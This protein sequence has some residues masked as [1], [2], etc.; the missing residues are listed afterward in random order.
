[1]LA[2]IFDVKRV[3]LK[4]L[5]CIIY[6]YVTRKLETCLQRVPRHR[7]S[8]AHVFFGEHFVQAGLTVFKCDVVLKTDKSVWPNPLADLRPTTKVMG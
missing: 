8:R 6:R 1:M 7:R 5:T 2:S 3:I 4:A